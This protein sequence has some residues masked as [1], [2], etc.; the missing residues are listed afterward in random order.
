MTGFKAV[1]EHGTVYEFDGNR[2]KIT[3]DK[4]GVSV[5]GV[6]IMKAVYHEDIPDGLTYAELHQYIRTLPE[7]DMAV[8]GAS[9]YVAGKDEWR[10]STIVTE[11][12]EIKE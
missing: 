11:V 3:S 7:V 10:L 4:F 6:W 1:T 5:F 8:E 12:E 2:V 9:L